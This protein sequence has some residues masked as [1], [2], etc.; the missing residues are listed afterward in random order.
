MKKL[1][2]VLL[3]VLMLISVFASCGGN[4]ETTTTEAPTTEAPTT[5]A[6]TTEQPTTEAPTTEAPTTETPTTIPPADDN[7]PKE[8]VTITFD[9]K[10][11]PKI[12]AQVVEKGSIVERP[13]TQSRIG[14]IFNGWF[15]NG[16]QWLGRFVVEEDTVVEA[17]WVPI[18]YDVYYELNGGINNEENMGSYTADTGIVFKDPTREGAKFLGWYTDVKFTEKI[19]E[20][21]K[22]ETGNHIL[23]ARWDDH[24]VAANDDILYF[25]VNPLGKGEYRVVKCIKEVEE[26]IIPIKYHSFDVTSI[27]VKAFS[28]RSSIKSIVIPNSI[29]D[30]YGD[31]FF[32]CTSL[33]SITIPNSVTHIEDNVFKNCTSLT[34]INVSDKNTKYKTIDGVLFSKDGK[35]LIAYPGGKGTSYSIPSHVTTI[36]EGAFYGCSSLTSITIPDSVSFIASSAFSHCTSLESITIPDGITSI[37]RETFYGCTSLKSISIPDSVTSIGYSAFSGCKSLT[38]IVIP[39][40]V[41]SIPDRTFYGCSSLT[42]V[43]IPSSVTSIGREAFKGCTSI[44]NATIPAIAIKHIQ[45]DNLKSVVIYGCT[46]LDGFSGCTVLDGFSGCT[47][48]ESVTIPDGVISINGNAFKGCAS[49]KSIVIPDSVTSIGGHAFDG[50]TSLTEI[51][52]PKSVIAMGKNVFSGCSSITVKCEAES[53]PGFWLPDWNSSN[54]PVVW[55]YKD[56]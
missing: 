51:I 22:G 55:G 29:T 28:G 39:D 42:E 24:S 27:S 47:L 26:V 31:A 2:T 11:G 14:Y 36:G 50:C 10:G 34:S 49:L 37:G 15:I 53:A 41:A 20:I 33:K 19:S 54:V 56:N 44:T 1:M 4:D 43:T 3:M 25:E 32:G 45:K 18:V 38:S 12:P 5:E 30:I 52:I 16:K 7:A 46:A 48:L 17:K 8:M 9:T 6:P 21:K 40:G 35:T 13:T 23:Y